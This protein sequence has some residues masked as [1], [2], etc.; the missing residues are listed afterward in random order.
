MKSNM[1]SKPKFKPVVEGANA[2]SLGISIVVALLLGVGI[3][4]GLL[5]LT[6]LAW[7]FWLGVFWGVGAAILNVYKAYK[8]AKKEL[9]DLAND[10]KYKLP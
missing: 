8:Q 1:E 10:P 5:K 4:Y 3:G 2:L 6:G 9:D 7:L